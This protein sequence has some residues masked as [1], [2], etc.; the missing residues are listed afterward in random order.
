MFYALVSE[1]PHADGG[2]EVNT[3]PMTHFEKEIFKLLE[4]FDLCICSYRLSNEIEAPG[5]PSP[6]AN[7]PTV[8]ITQC[9][10]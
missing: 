4:E 2:G 9:P 10:E 7:P 8:I 1:R 5:E 3:L 6:R